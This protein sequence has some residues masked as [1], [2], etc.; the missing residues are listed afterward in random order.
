MFSLLILDADVYELITCYPQ[1]KHSRKRIDH[2][3]LRI[4]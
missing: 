4:S 2:P 3:F 1:Q